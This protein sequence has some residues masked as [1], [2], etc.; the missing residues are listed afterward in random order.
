[1]QQPLP[2]KIGAMQGPGSFRLAGEIADGVHVACGH[3]A[4]ALACAAEADAAGGSETDSRRSG[5]LAWPVGYW[6]ETQHHGG[7]RQPDRRP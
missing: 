4:K 1:V 5:F 6:A 2:P 3:S 7:S